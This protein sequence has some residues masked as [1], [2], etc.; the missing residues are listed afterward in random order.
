MSRFRFDGEAAAMI[1]ALVVLAV[2][3]GWLIYN[4]VVTDDRKWECERRGGVVVD[5]RGDRW[6]C[7][8]IRTDSPGGAR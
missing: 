5:G 7:V 1:A 8:G 3:F 4:G 6:H 2:I